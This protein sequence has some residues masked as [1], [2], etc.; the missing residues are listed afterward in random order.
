MTDLYTLY[1]EINQ[2]YDQGNMINYELAFNA[3]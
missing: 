2:K 3:L 1:E